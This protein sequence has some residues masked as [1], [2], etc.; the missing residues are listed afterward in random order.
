MSEAVSNNDLDHDDPERYLSP[1][2]NI[3][4]DHPEVIAFAKKTVGDATDHM[5]LAEKLYYAV[6]DGIKYDPYATT[7]IAINPKASYCLSRGRGFCILKSA[8]MAAAS[9][10]LGIPARVGYAD[11]RNHLSSKRLQELLE[12][13]LYI[14]HGYVELYLEGKWVKMTPVFDLPLCEKFKVLP[15]DF[16]GRNDSI[17][18]PNNAE[19]KRHMEYVNEH[20]TFFDVPAEMIVEE[21]TKLY[22]NVMNE[23]D[24]QGDFAAE[25]AAES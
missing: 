6:R 14:Y 4:S 19:G 8:L 22:P 20:G 21:F 5:E 11:V 23:T 15:L 18:H 13:D 10:C 24:L 7:D 3:D 17:F 9:R 2:V 1:G 12:T 16:D 25:A